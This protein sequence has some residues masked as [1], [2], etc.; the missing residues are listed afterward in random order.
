MRRVLVLL[1]VGCAHPHPHVHGAASAEAPIALPYR[2]VDGQSAAPLDEA[3]LDE[4]LRAARVIY[5][6]EEH[7]NPHHHAVE[8]DL[9]ERVWRIDPDVALGLEMLPRTLQPAL[10]DYLAGK[11]DERAFLDAVDWP[12]TWGYP[13]GLY[14]PLLAFCRAHHLRAFALNAPRALAHAVAQR[15]L[16]GLSADEKAQLP[17]LQPGPEPHREMVREAFGAHPHDGKFNDAKFERFYAAQLVWDETMAERAAAALP[18]VHRLVVV[19]G[20]MHARRF[21]VP[22]RAARRG[23]APYL[24]VEPLFER[25]LDDARGVADVLWV[26]LPK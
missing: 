14:R 7:P 25:E 11:L 23:A 16:D 12:H 15:G 4:R 13:F 18:S 9:L 5:V 6:G 17:E 24:I 1:L 2:L 20:E 22:D 19:A 26:L 10:D 3:A 21:A 8:I